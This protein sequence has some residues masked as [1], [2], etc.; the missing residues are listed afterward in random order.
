MTPPNYE[1]YINYIRPDQPAVGNGFNAI[2]QPDSLEG[3]SWIV[4]G[5]RQLEEGIEILVDY[6]DQF[7]G[8][9]RPA[10]PAALSHAPVS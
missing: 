6:E 2:I 8:S 9:S 10:I 1:R 4:S 5:P 7:W 3:F